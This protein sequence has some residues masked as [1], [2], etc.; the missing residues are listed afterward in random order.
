LHIDEE[1]I[2]NL[3]KSGL[4]AEQDTA[5]ATF[6]QSGNAQSRGEGAQEEC[7]GKSHRGKSG[8]FGI[9]ITVIYH[10][11]RQ[12]SCPLIPR[13]LQI[14]I[15]CIYRFIIDIDTYRSSSDWIFLLPIASAPAT[16]VLHQLVTF[17]KKLV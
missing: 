9:A 16:T 4:S 5:G 11:L 13:P 6:P 7:R 8:K 17:T 10:I 15:T 2:S 1:F 14:P 12:F 3:R